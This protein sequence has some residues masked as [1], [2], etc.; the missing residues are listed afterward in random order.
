MVAWVMRYSPY[1]VYRCSGKDG[2]K[3]D[4][5]NGEQAGDFASLFLKKISVEGWERQ[6]GNIKI[7]A[8]DAR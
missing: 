7:R 1:D 2:K 5:A 8:I 6:I 4:Y 3:Y